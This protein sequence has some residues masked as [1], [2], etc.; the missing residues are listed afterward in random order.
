M[1]T[2]GQRAA[3]VAG[4]GSASII[5]IIGLLGIFLGTQPGFSIQ[6]D[7]LSNLRQDVSLYLKNGSK[8]GD[9]LGQTRLYA[10]GLMNAKPTTAEDVLEYYDALNEDPSLSGASIYSRSSGAQHALI[11][12]FYLWN[13][14][15]IEKEFAFYIQLDAYLPPR[16]L[17][18]N[19]PYSYLRILTIVGP[20]DGSSYDVTFYGA[21]NDQGTGT[22]EGGIADSRECISGHRNISS[23][24]DK[25]LREPTFLYKGQGFCE[26][27]AE[28]TDCIVTRY[29]RSLPHEM[30]RFSI[31]AYLEGLDPD[32]TK[33]APEGCRLSL[34]AHFGDPR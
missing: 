21:A 16:N 7:D 2:N 4:V 19:H 14:S 33:S 5:G 17:N 11:Y 30:M 8:A 32:C 23:N 22:V 27:F 26:S 25:T 29:F 13:F 15:E 34:S 31:I 28:D 1:F 10:P 18:V 20:E 12:T 6:I 24:Q 3:L 9:S